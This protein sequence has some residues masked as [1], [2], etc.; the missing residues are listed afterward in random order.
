MAS[1]PEVTLPDPLPPLLSATQLR[2]LLGL[3][4]SDPPTDE[5]LTFV[6]EVASA[7]IRGNIG[8]SLTLADYIDTFY[9]IDPSGMLSLSEYPVKD[10]TEV[11]VSGVTHPGDTFRVHAKTGIL[12]A[13]SSFTVGDP[14]VVKYEA[15]YAT[16]PHDIQA[17]MLELSRQQLHSMG[18]PNGAVDINTPIRAVSIGALRVEYAVSLTASATKGAQASVLTSILKEYEATLQPY[19][20]SRILASVP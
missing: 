16:I 18:L 2:S 10:I 19:R 14:V 4:A 17:V 13:P 5:Q 12:Y 1:F 6:S 9:D 20:H 3:G 8:R 15:G 11:D 7:S